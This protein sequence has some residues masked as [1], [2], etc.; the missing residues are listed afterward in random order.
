[1]RLLSYRLADP[2]LPVFTQGEGSAPHA[3]VQDELDRLADVLSYDVV[4]LS[5]GK[6]VSEGEAFGER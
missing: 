5:C 4:A 1:M 6:G 2:A 3:S